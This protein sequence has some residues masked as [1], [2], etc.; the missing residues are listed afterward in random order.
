MKEF[1][2]NRFIQMFGRL[3]ENEKEFAKFSL[4]GGKVWKN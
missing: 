1:C 4:F 3:P 2:L